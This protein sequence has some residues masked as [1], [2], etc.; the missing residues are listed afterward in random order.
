MQNKD[1]SQI[2]LE[3]IKESGIKPISKNVFNLKRV[4]FWSLVGFSVVVGG[5]SFSVML[6]ILFSNDWTLYNKFG[7]NFILKTLPYFWFVCLLVLTFLGES[8]YRKTLLGYRHRMVTIIGIYV[9]LMIISGTTLYII[10][11]GESIEQSLSENVP[12]YHGFMFDRTEVWSHPEEG[13][14]SGQIIKVESNQIE[15]VDFNN[16]VWIINIEKSFISSQLQIKKGEIIKIIGYMNND[17]IFNA[18]QIR[19]WIKNK[20]NQNNPMFNMMR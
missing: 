11:I 12:I 15:L 2:A 6:S 8:Y 17:G 1:I 5:L 7:F 20:L 18:E 9:I 13:L 14:L 19:P 3:R 10:G 4:L 16:F